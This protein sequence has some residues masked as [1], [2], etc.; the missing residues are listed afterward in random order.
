MTAILETM[1][2]GIENNLDKVLVLTM[3][4]WSVIWMLSYIIYISI[5]Q[6]TG[7]DGKLKYV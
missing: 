2:R 1:T 7:K 5:S 3:K 4:R 6:T